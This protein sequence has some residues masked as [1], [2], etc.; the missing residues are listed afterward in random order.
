MQPEN[1]SS[2]ES[3]AAVQALSPDVLVVAAYG[4]ILRQ[5]LL[6]VPARGSLN[7]H[8]S[9][10]PRHRGASPIAA[11]ILAGDEVTGVTVME[12]VRALDAGP[13]VSRIEEPILPS[14]TTGSL[15][16]RLSVAGGELLASTLDAWAAG[17]IV[18]EPQDDTLATYAPQLKREDALL[19]WSVPAA[20]LWREV[21]A[22]NPWPI[23]YI[24]WREEELRIL[25]AWPL[26]GDS[27]SEPGTVLQSEPLPAETQASEAT[28]SVQTGSGRLAILRLQ[29]PGRKPVSGAEFLRGQ[30]NFVGTKLG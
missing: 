3:V 8:A 14:D 9:L 2:P 18:A 29:R 17:E 5:R 21:R 24:R 12:V 27:G 30:R 19:E 1:V 15:E 10:L 6:D 25:E 20:D 7:V 11:A 16:Q 13:M 22:Y 23:A 4:Q 28:F 26:E